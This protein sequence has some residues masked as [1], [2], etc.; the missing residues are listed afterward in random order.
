MFKKIEIWILYLVILIMIIFVILFGVLVR[1]ELVGTVKLGQVSRAALFLSEIPMNIKKLIH[2]AKDP[3]VDL[4]VGERF[5]GKF[6]FIGN[7][8]QKEYFLLLSR[9]DGDKSESTVEL[10]DLKNQEIIQTWNPDIKNINSLIDQTRE[11]YLLLNRD[12]KENRYK[13]YSPI[14]SSDGGLVFHGNGSPLI[15]IGK[16]NELHWIND[17]DHFH[18]SNEVDLNNNYWIPSR[19]FPYSLDTKKIGKKFGDF[20]DDAIT[21]VSVDGEILF[22]KSVTQILLENDMEHLVFSDYVFHGDPIHLND[23][24]PVEKSGPYW[25][26]GDLF[27]SLRSQNMIILYRPSTNKVIRTITGPFSNQHDVDIINNKEISI[28]N[29]NIYFF[30]GDRIDKAR[31]HFI[32]MPENGNIEILIYNFETGEFKKKFSEGIN[33]NNVRTSVAGLSEIMND[34]S[35]FIEETQSG[36]VLFF[37]NRGKLVLEYINKAKNGKNYSLGFSRLIEVDNKFK[38]KLE[39]IKSKKC[40]N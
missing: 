9:Y 25:K 11:E 29:N 23:I 4:G 39:I 31:I 6:G 7:F 3:G 27:L 8:V 16:C 24:Q 26:M 34:G 19:I 20:F 40:I 37:D 33:I 36:R 38:E 22:Q 21:K 1:Q 10:I 13:I 18:H 30:K 15:K 17:V 14:I 28:F 12:F 35:L 5:K 32:G 2:V